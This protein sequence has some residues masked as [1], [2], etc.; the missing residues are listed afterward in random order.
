M[1]VKQAK[2]SSW[3]QLLLTYE[4]LRF[5][6]VSRVQLIGFQQEQPKHPCKIHDFISRSTFSPPWAQT[7]I[8]PAQTC[9]QSPTF[10]F[11]RTNQFPRQRGVGGV[12]QPLLDILKSFYCTQKFILF[13]RWSWSS[14][15]FIPQ[16]GKG[17]ASVQ[18][19]LRCFPAARC[20]GTSVCPWTRAHGGGRMQLDHAGLLLLCAPPALLR[21]GRLTNQA[22]FYCT[23]YSKVHF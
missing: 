16:K 12:N 20:S 7:P 9:H 13:P 5:G 18:R 23:S 19:M 2:H 11:L 4:T 6:T 1:K 17:P 10:L 15:V 22:V 8:S 3:Q 21:H 14:A